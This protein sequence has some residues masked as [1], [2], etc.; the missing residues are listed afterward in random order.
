[1]FLFV[2]LIQFY[3]PLKIIS[4]HMRG[5]RKRENPE[6]IHMA[7]PQA[8]FIVVSKVTLVPCSVTVR[9]DMA[10]TARYDT[11]RNGM[12]GAV[13]CEMVPEE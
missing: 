3:V 11:L 4:A 6:K 9:N 2:F 12:V 1:M 8:E 13:H 7:H 5:R 10:R